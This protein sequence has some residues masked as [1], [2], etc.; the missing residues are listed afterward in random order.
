MGTRMN[1]TA[2]RCDM[3]RGGGGSER[4]RGRS[5]FE[6]GEPVEMTN[7]VGRDEKER[8]GFVLA[9]DE[10]SG[11]EVRLVCRPLF[12]GIGMVLELEV[13]EYKHFD[14]SMERPGAADVALT[15]FFELPGDFDTR[16]G[17]YNQERDCWV[18]ELGH[19]HSYSGEA[20]L[21]V[22]QFPEKGG[23]I[24]NAVRVRVTEEQ[25]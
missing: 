13:P 16:F 7:F 11:S 12:G 21:I 18:I 9:R 17:S 24:Q 5:R 15:G 8:Q 20:V 23:L 2:A 10:K 3:V 6:D 19:H 14:V 22:N 1:V 4:E 25:G